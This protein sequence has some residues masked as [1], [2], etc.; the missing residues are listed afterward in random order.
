MHGAVTMRIKSQNITRPRLRRPRRPG[1]TC[2]LCIRIEN[3]LNRHAYFW[4]SRPLV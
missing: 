4:G 2:H 3:R 1:R